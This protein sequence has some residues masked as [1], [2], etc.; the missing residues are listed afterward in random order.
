M[1]PLNQ[2]DNIRQGTLTHISTLFDEMDP[3]TVFTFL[4]G[5]DAPDILT[6]MTNQMPVN[7][8][9][10]HFGCARS[11]AIMKELDQ[12]IYHKVM[13][14][15]DSRK[16]TTAQKHAALHYLVFLEQKCCGQ[17]K[18]YSCADGHKPCVYKKRMTLNPPQSAQNHCSLPVLLMPWRG[19]MW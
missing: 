12:L 7:C 9:L 8:G 11:E 1:T 4:T 3:E 17:I 16:L 13:E 14:G 19:I 10:K 2:C 18:G 15:H 5:P 6:F